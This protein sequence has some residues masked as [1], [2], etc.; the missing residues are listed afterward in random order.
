MSSQLMIV[1]RL[2]PFQLWISLC[3]KPSI[4]CGH[5]TRLFC[6]F[7]ISPRPSL[8]V[9]PPAPLRGC[10]QRRPEVQAG[11]R[12]SHVCLLA[13]LLTQSEYFY[14]FWWCLNNTRGSWAHTPDHTLFSW[15]Q[16]RP[17]G[18][19]VYFAISTLVQYMV[20]GSACF[21]KHAVS[22]KPQTGTHLHGFYRPPVATFPT[23][24]GKS[25]SGGSTFLIKNVADVQT[26]IGA[27]SKCFTD[28]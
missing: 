23:L 12:R 9:P 18:K 7:I 10:L 17:G 13:V 3:S 11:F 16:G 6:P 2:F 20:Q 21:Q 1:T 24:K 19:W 28:C 27:R 14:D 22:L 5:E 8:P 26:D 25:L 15:S 4:P